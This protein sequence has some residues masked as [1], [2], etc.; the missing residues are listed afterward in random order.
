[1]ARLGYFQGPW[2]SFE[3]VLALNIYSDLVPVTSLRQSCRASETVTSLKKNDFPLSPPTPPHTLSLGAK[4]PRHSGVGVVDSGS[5]TPGKPIPGLGKWVVC[6]REREWPSRRATGLARSAGG[7]GAPGCSPRGPAG[8]S[9]PPRGGEDP[10]G[11][12][13]APGTGGTWVPGL[14]GGWALPGRAGLLAACGWLHPRE[15]PGNPVCVSAGTDR[16]ELTSWK[17]FPSIFKFFAEASE[18]RSSSQKPAL[19]RRS[20]RIKHEEL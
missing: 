11:R 18:A 8:E 13:R 6:R 14:A 4:P 7:R 15:T 12:R 2:S 17:S 20:H 3:S 10:R 19:T 5:R 9:W 16:H 1:M